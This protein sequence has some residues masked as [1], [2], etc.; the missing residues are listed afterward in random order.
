MLT[1]LITARNAANT[2]QRAI[3]SC[4]NEPAKILL[5]DDHCTDDTVAMAKHVAGGKL[6]V[7]PAPEPGGLP[8]ARQAGLDA[9][10]TPYAAWLDA[11]DAWIPG[12]AERI[13]AALHNGCD[14]VT[15]TIDLYDGVKGQF[16]R[17]LS[18]PGFISDT[19]GHFRLF[20]R[21]Y[22][23]GDTQVGFRVETLRNAGGYDPTIFSSE[24]YDLLLRAIANGATFYHLP[25][26]GYRMY[27]Y[28]RSVSRD[29]AGIRSATATSLGKHRYDDVQGLCQNA[30]YPPRIIAWLLVSMA[31]FREEFDAALEFLEE[32]SP[33]DCDPMEIIDIE[34]PYP[35]PEGWRRAFTEGTLRLLLGNHD[36]MAAMALERAESILCT[37]EGANNL[38]VAYRRLE[39]SAHARE[40]F[41]EALDRFP[42]YLDAQLNL[43]EDDGCHIT[44]HP[45]RRQASR[46]EYTP[47][48]QRPEG[49]SVKVPRVKP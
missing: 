15:D 46:S 16:L 48:F 29:L 42:G 27:A 8:I 24:S 17:H 26:S 2:I 6:H 9:V 40:W 37:A 25:E 3:L 45:L 31:T 7:M 47:V 36:K 34:G 20:E 5:V 30:G 10:E 35:L 39:K 4:L 33:V 19:S 22:L 14:I 28:P 13:I 32:A 38:G 21:N 23:P 11:D 12:R 1:I 44:T 43:K 18:V 41:A 49:V